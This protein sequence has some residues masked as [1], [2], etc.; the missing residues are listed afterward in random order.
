MRAA[1]YSPERAIDYLTGGI[2]AHLRSIAEGMP[3][4]P[5]PQ[6]QIPQMQPQAS[7]QP[8]P[9]SSPQQAAPATV[10]AP[11]PVQPQAAPAT[12]PNSQLAGLFRQ[13]PNFEQMRAAVQQDPRLLRPILTTI[14]SRNPELYA[15]ITQNT[16]E[17]IQL[18][19]QP[20]PGAQP[21]PAAQQQPAGMPGMPIIPGMQGM[22]AERPGTIII[23]QQEKQAID[24]LVNMGFDR[25]MA[26][27]AYLTFKD[28]NLAANFLLENQ[29]FAMAGGQGAGMEG[30]EGEMEEGEMEE[31]EGEEGEQGEQGDQA[32]YEEDFDDEMLP[33]VAPP[34]QPQQ[35]QQ[36]SQPQQ[37]PTQSQ[38][39]SQP[40]QPPKPEEKKDE[41]KK[42][43]EDKQ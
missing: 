23:S 34:A 39:Q 33:P 2:P 8:A 18:L 36:Q 1:Y 9:V 31:M 29:D 41:E 19:T 17:F 7:P 12:G 43:D 6:R 20:Q 38:P 16:Q 42:M 21:A 4:M 26:A 3:T 10:P 25:V 30:F 37:P 35:P 28:E 40:Q 22:P 13:I 32:L 14:A 11:A 27:Q 24:N 15:Q 5:S